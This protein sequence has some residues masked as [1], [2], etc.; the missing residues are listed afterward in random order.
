MRIDIVVAPCRNELILANSLENCSCLSDP[1]SKYL[2]IAD[3]KYS[4]LCSLS[5]AHC[6][7]QRHRTIG[8]VNCPV[9]YLTFYQTV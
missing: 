4:G 7:D 1:I 2:S 9:Y 3:R 5:I 6:P 8:L